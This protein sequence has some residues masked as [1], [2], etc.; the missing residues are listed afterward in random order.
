VPLLVR[1]FLE[2]QRRSYPEIQGVTEAALKRMVE[3]DWPGN[4]RE[5]QALIERLT[6]LR[7]SGW[8]DEGELPSNV[9]GHAL[10]RPAVSLPATGVDFEALVSSYE[11]GLILQALEATS[12]NKNRASQLLGLKRTTL[13]EKIRAKGISAPDPE[14]PPGRPRVS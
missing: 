14:L 12:W 2:V 1:H 11:Q 5:L 6:I 10:E 13:V 7:R 3:Y 8:V 4:V 9:A